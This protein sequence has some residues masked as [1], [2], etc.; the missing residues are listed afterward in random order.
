M[1][2][3]VSLLIPDFSDE[4]WNVLQ[5][6]TPFLTIVENLTKQFDDFMETN[7]TPSDTTNYMDVFN[8]SYD[9]SK[10]I[11]QQTFE[12]Y[13]LDDHVLSQMKDSITDIFLYCMEKIG[14]DTYQL[15]DPYSTA[16]L[17]YNNFILVDQRQ[18]FFEHAMDNIIAHV[19]PHSILFSAYEKMRRGDPKPLYELIADIDLSSGN[20][21]V[22]YLDGSGNELIAT[23]VIQGFIP[24]NI[25]FDLFLKPQSTS[26]AYSTYYMH[27]VQNLTTMPKE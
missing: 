13:E 12:E 9:I 21:I 22:N 25:M 16:Y 11:H 27:K 24:E 2:I 20:N 23:Q 4:Q 1:S 17:L 6:S 10:Q 3:E 7:A 19:D 14:C 8:D 26:L 18:S 5:G 15:E